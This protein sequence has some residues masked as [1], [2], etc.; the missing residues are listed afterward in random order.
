MPP[1]KLPPPKPGEGSK[2]SSSQ[3]AR[4]GNEPQQPEPEIDHT[5]EIQEFIAEEFAR[6]TDALQARSDQLIEKLITL[7][8]SLGA[9]AKRKP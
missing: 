8:A 1:R 4:P 9:N 5:P 3:K 2:P 7:D 6:I